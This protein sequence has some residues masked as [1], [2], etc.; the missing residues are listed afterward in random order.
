M[1]KKKKQ[2]QND[3][4]LAQEALET[5]ETAQAYT[6]DIPED[7]ERI[8]HKRIRY[9]PGF[10]EYIHSMYHNVIIVDDVSEEKEARGPYYMQVSL[11][12]KLEY[13]LEDDKGIDK[14]EWT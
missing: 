7:E 10:L 8:C 3:D 1:S 12:G 4:F 5:Q 13:H 6:L 11:A 14:P 2:K 9:R